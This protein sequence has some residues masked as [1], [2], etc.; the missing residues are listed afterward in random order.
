MT[1]NKLHGLFH[2]LVGDINGISLMSQMCVQFVA[3]IESG[4]SDSRLREETA[5]NFKNIH[6][7]YD[8]VVKDLEVTVGTLTEIESSDIGDALK[9]S[10]TDEL[11]KINKLLNNSEDFDHEILKAD[12][13]KDFSHFTQELWKIEPICASMVETVNFSKKKLIEQG[14]Y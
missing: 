5:S 2:E 8:R 11:K 13:K 6:L 4:N 9:T 12:N 14:K 10:I 1:N 3:M 7:Y